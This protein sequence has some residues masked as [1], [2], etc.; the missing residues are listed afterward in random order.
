MH[1]QR[2]T[3]DGQR[4]TCP[5]AHRVILVNSCSQGADQHCECYQGMKMIDGIAHILCDYGYEDRKTSIILPRG[6]E[7]R[8]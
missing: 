8:K 5:A 6:L 7:V 2:V 1:R 4:T 3:L